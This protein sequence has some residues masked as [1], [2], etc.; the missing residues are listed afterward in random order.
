[1]MRLPTSKLT[2]RPSR[3]LELTAAEAE[4][5]EFLQPLSRDY[6]NF[7]RWYC[8]RVVPGARMGTRMVLPVRKYGRLIAIG[9][10]KNEGGEP[11][12]CTVR[13]APEFRGRRLGYHIFDCLLRW[14]DIDYP[15]FTLRAE[16]LWMFERIIDYYGFQLT[17][18]MPGYVPGATEL[19]FNGVPHDVGCISTT[20]IGHIESSMR[21]PR[22]PGGLHWS[23]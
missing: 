9:I 7:A 19:A 4:V 14:L 18:A 6:P 22:A 12:I 3:Q 21:L 16:K 2:L 15:H 13:I 17:A 23:A 11:K 1:M 10:A 20:L 5:L 8:S